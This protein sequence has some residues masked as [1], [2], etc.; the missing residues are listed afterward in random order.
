M[1]GPWEHRT[2]GSSLNGK[3]MRSAK[4]T[5]YSQDIKTIVNKATIGKAL[6]SMRNVARR[7][8]SVFSSCFYTFQRV[9]SLPLLINLNF[10]LKF[11]R[12][13]ES[14]AFHWNIRRMTFRPDDPFILPIGVAQLAHFAISNAPVFAAS[15]RSLSAGANNGLRSCRERARIEMDRFPLRIIVDLI[16][17]SYPPKIDVKRYSAFLPSFLKYRRSHFLRPTRASDPAVT[18][19]LQQ[20]SPHLPLPP[21]LQLV[22]LAQTATFIHAHLRTAVITPPDYWSS[23]HEATTVLSPSP[24]LFPP[25]TSSTPPPHTIPRDLLFAIS[26]S[27]QSTAT[28]WSRRGRQA[29]ASCRTSLGWHVYPT[30]RCLC[31]PGDQANRSLSDWNCHWENARTCHPPRASERATSALDLCHL[32]IK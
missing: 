14:N 22:A 18:P 10:K 20:T 1:E 16:R 23:N 2:R 11:K 19:E 25:S 30:C 13:K 9:P 21:P 4:L 24:S 3:G 8:I 28:T 15:P 5:R 27:P 12:W 17:G 32:V 7:D 31:D 26:P 29:Q 6:N